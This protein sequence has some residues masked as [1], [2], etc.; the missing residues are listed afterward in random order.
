MLTK[1]KKTAKKWLV[2]LL[3]LTLSILI[4][5][6]VASYIVDPFFVYRFRDDTYI[7]SSQ[8]ALPGIIKNA[9]YDAA[10]VGSSMIQNFKMSS[11]RDKLGC[12]ALKLSY[13]G[14]SLT[15]FSKLYKSLKKQGKSQNYYLC[16]D[17]YLFAYQ[18]SE[19]K[20]RMA[21]YLIDTN[22][23]NDYPYLLGYATW[24]RFIP[25]DL[26][27]LAVER[28]DISLPEKFNRSKK[29]DY[30]ED[31][32]LEAVTGR[33]VVIRNYQAGTNNVSSIDLNDLYDRM[34][35]R[36][37]VFIQGID[38]SD[39]NV[40]FFFPPY[41]ALFWYTAESEG[42]F[43]TYMSVKSYLI[44]ALTDKQNV[45]VYDFQTE[46]FIA[47]LDNYCDMTHYGPDINDWMIDCF[48]DGHD[49][50]CFSDNDKRNR[51]LEQIVAD[52]AQVNADWL[53]TNLQ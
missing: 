16:L 20:D 1:E 33:D 8:F 26:G 7:I 51:Q 42:Y 53:N 24:M 19:D 11:F 46:E 39:G 43:D 15:E 48:V 9:D 27:F 50:A 13:S 36:V 44:E 23:I 30:T 35:N 25:T 32:S 37:D 14:I 21:D 40:V 12:N 6:C 34:I 52:F 38:C 49:L 41:S 10:I 4:L 47:D 5:L 3:C 17:M 28:L 18:E 22:Y 29:L 31:W 2:G 45:S